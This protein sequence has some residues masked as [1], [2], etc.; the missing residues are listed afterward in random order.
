M[1]RGAKAL[2]FALLCLVAD[3]CRKPEPPPPAAPLPSKSIVELSA[4]G[5]QNAQVQTAKLLPQTFGPR[6]TTWATLTAAPQD[7][8]RLG[9]R[10]SGRVVAIHVQL[11]DA[12]QKGQPLVEI[13]AV[14][15]HQVSTEYLTAV[16]RAKET[17]D[18]LARQKQLVAERV[19]ALAELRRAEA[20]A[21]AAH[22]TLSEADEH[23]HFLGLTDDAI[24]ALRAGSSHGSERSVLRAPFAGRVAALSVALGQVLAGSEDIVTITRAATIQAILRVYERDLA[25]IA[26]GTPVELKV[27]SYPD[28]P[29]RG[30]LVALGGLIDASSRTI[31]GRVA[32]ANE[33]GALKP[34]MSATAVLPLRSAAPKLYLPAQAVQTDGVERVVF[35][36]IG[37]R[38]FEA[39]PVVVG[40][41]QGGVVAIESG[42]QSGTEVVVHGA[43]ALR[44]QLER[45]ALEE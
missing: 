45:A 12:V 18:A 26:E 13:D 39:R 7:I 34:G 30:T 24:R 16:A 6:L 20:N 27:P 23:L 44:A 11:G 40:P 33:D 41:E 5:M 14:E 38:R 43:F 37:E 9:A 28:R 36:A 8:A 19:G 4:E 3:G 15:L 29:L 1:T 10:V 32:I 42:L 31:E 35:V 25:G 2:W 21:A 17:D 22:A